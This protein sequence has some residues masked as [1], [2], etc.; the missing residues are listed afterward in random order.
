[1][2]VERLEERFTMPAQ[3]G[4]W[5]HQQHG[6]SPAVNDSRKQN[7]QTALVGLE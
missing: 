5:L 7:R 3:N 6:V 1:M 4:L 2:R